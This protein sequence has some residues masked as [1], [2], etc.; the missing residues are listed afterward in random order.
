MSNIVKVYI[1]KNYDNTIKTYIVKS[2]APHELPFPSQKL[3]NKSYPL[4]EEQ[5]KIILNKIKKE[6]KNIE[7]SNKIL[8]TLYTHSKELFTI[9]QRQK[10][11]HN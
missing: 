2:P 1:D 10:L 8:K 4:L 7:E 5:M 3:L 6:E 11:A 9:Y